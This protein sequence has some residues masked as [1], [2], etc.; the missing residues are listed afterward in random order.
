MKNSLV[1][2][3][4]NIIVSCSIEK[5]KKVVNIFETFVKSS[6]KKIPLRQVRT[7]DKKKLKIRQISKIPGEVFD[8]T[9]MLE[10]QKM[11]FRR[12][13]TGAQL[14]SL[15]DASPKKQKLKK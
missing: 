6:P 8:I 1:S 9:D 14:E 3:K 11:I 7:E 2:H 4:S 15:L 12:N 5:D 10:S 13:S